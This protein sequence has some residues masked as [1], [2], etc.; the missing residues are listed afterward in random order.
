MNPTP[1]P[2]NGGQ[3]MHAPPP[4]TAVRRK[5]P[6]GDIFFSARK[7]GPP[8]LHPS[9]RPPPSHLLNGNAGIPPRPITPASARSASPASDKIQSQDTTSGFSDP[10]LQ[11]SG[12]LYTDYRLVTTKREVLDGLRY[13]VL[14]L[15]SEKA[16]DI[17]NESEFSKPA[18]LHRRDPRAQQMTTVRQ[19]FEDKLGLNPQEREEFNKKREARQKERA[20]NLAMVAP[21]LGPTRKVNNAKKKT[22]QVFHRDFTADDKRRIQ[23]NYEEKLPWHLEDFDSKHCFVG[24]NQMGNA[25]TRVAFVLEAGTDGAVPKYRMIPVEKIYDFQTKRETKIPKMTIEEVEKRMKRHGTEPEWLIRQREARV[26]EQYRDVVAKRAKGIV[27]AAQED[28]RAGRQGEDADLDFDD[29]FADDEEGDLFIEKDEDTKLADSRI[30]EDQLLANIFDMKEE[31]EYD[32]AEKR[33][34]RETAARKKN[35]KGIRKALERRERNYNHGSDSEASWGS[36]VSSR[37][38]YLSLNCANISTSLSLRMK[39]TKLRKI[40]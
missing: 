23:T 12:T 2:S 40:V 18:R 35:F 37:V 22:Q 1:S 11:A 5:K 34:Q 14:H 38:I 32:L 33:E 16:L 30:K 13:H 4:A 15:N 8:R 27:S 31:K 28:T 9:T 39:R 36:S 6:Q 29:D 21:S 26:A 19:E 25:Q 20:E 3:N 24:K 7:S 10:S 17:R